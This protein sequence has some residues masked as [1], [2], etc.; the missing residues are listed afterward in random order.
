MLQSLKKYNVLGKNENSP[1]LGELIFEL[2][3]PFRH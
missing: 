3:K 1:Y 2:E